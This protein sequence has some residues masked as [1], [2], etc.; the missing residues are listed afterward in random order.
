MAGGRIRRT[1]KALAARAGT[2]VV[3]VP[4]GLGRGVRLQLD[5][6][7]ELML[8]VGLY[9]HELDSHLGRLC[10]GAGTAYDVG[11]AI[12]YDS[13]AIARRSGGEVVAF[14]ADPGIAERFRT[15]LA[16]NPELR[17]RIQLERSRVGRGGDSTVALDDLVT[18]A[19]FPIPSLLKID[20]EGEEIE[21]LAGG[22]EL[23]R[24]HHPAVVLETHS[25]ALEDECREVLEDHGYRVLV[26]ER[27]RWLRESRPMA[28]NR[29]LVAV[30]R[31]A[32][33]AGLSDAGGS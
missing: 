21:V 32:E 3:R 13:L 33:P 19:R 7:H 29:W 22:R 14:E 4:F 8:A 12:G 16:L 24:R 15:N 1:I 27:R 10:R 5:L 11:A 18:S 28:H 23:L 20:V 31:A 17:P 26:V 2:R 6:S 25:E 30:Q 9:E